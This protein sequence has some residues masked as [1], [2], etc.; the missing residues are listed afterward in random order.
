[1][2]KWIDA[3]RCPNVKGLP[4]DVVRTLHHSIVDIVRMR[5]SIER[6]DKALELSMLAAFESCE[7]LKRVRSDGLGGSR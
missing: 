7:L 4:D 1:M 2:P 5:R 3:L 6:T